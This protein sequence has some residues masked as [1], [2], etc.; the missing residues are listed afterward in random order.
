M[1]ASESYWRKMPSVKRLV[2][3]SVPE[4]TTRVAMLKR[5]EVDV[6]YLLDAPQAIELQKD[7]NFRVAFS[8]GIATFYLAFL[9]MWHSKS[10]SAYRPCPRAATSAIARR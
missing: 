10:P 4:A 6:A 8:G 1:E 2:F 9:V 7:R 3:K 5:G